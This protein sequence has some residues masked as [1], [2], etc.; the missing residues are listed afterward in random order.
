[1]FFNC[2]VNS[3]CTEHDVYLATLGFRP[4][5]FVDALNEAIV[6]PRAHAQELVERHAKLTR[7]FT[8]MS[9]VDMTEDP[10]FYPSEVT[11]DVSNIHTARLI[12]ECAPE[13]F[14]YSAPQKM[15]LPSGREVR[16]REGVVYPGTD[17]MYCVDRGSGAFSPWTPVDR[18]RETAGIRSRE[19]VSA[20]GGGICSASP[21]VSGSTGGAL[22]LGGIALVVV[23]MRRRRRA[24]A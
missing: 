9:A 12:T 11:R 4:S 8:T 17:E 14:Y 10:V 15:I 16:T 22:A 18:L 13:Y 23:V 1:M 21:G 3:W 7:L 5:E 19:A 6:T 2:L 24:A 20:H